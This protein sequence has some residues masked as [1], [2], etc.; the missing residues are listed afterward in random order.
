MLADTP[1]RD[2]FSEH[3][4][5][6]ALL[7]DA[8][9][10]PRAARALEGLVTAP[11]LARCTVSFSHYLFGALVRGGRTD[12]LLKRLDLWRDMAAQGLKTPLEGP[13]D[14]RSDCHAWGSH[15]AYHLLTGVAGVR[16]DAPGF[17][18]VR[19]APQP[20]GLKRI[21]A[22]VPS[23]RGLVRVDLRFDGEAV[24]GTVTLP[25]GLPGTFA[26]QG[27]ETPLTGGVNVVG[28]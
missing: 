27:A 16:P 7:A 3:A 11:D 22:G 2:A 13:G 25:E 24:S 5:S 9:D 17:A 14:A 19:V 4:Q 18:R 10:A 1:A 26:W 20:G 15:P 28:D 6:L 12:V 23:P 21:E 8:L